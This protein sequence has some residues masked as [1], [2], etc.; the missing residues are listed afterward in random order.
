MDLALRVPI[1]DQRPRALLHGDFDGRRRPSFVV[2]VQKC[3]LICY[4]VMKLLFILFFLMVPCLL[5]KDPVYVVLWFDTEDYVDPM[6]D[7]AALRIANDLTKLNV[8]DL[9]AG[10]RESA[11]P[12][13]AKS[14]GR[15]SSFVASQRVGLSLELA[16]RSARAGR[17]L[18][19][20]GMLE[21][22]EEFERRELAGALDVKRIFG[23]MPIC[24]GQPGS[25]WAPQ[26]YPAL[27]HM[28]IPVYLDDGAQIGL[29]DQPF[30]YDGILTIYNLG[31]YAIPPRSDHE[32]ENPAIYRKFVADA[33]KL[34]DNGGGVD[35]HL[36]PPD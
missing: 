1:A 11:G 26:T 6:S 23:M 5:A 7:D 18:K 19:Q 30:W 12:R 17:L 36:F 25:S 29:E 21:G 31:Q 4:A 27:R 22:E 34:A 28:G 33:G 32:Q 14:R 2:N 35:Q 13:K 16:Q 3:K 9:Q 8:R 15:H 24:Y 20:L 10:R